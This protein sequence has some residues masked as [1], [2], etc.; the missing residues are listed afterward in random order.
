MGEDLAEKTEEKDATTAPQNDSDGQVG[1]DN[2]SDEQADTSGKKPEAEPAEPKLAGDRVDFFTT[3][4]SVSWRGNVN[5][6]YAGLHASVPAHDRAPGQKPG[7]STYGAE[8]EVRFPDEKKEVYAEMERIVG[9]P[10]TDRS[11]ALR[12]L[13]RRWHPDKNPEDMDRAT[14]VFNYLQELKEEFLG[15]GGGGFRAL[16]EEL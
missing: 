1:P 10:R 7:G 9:L 8:E 13:A 5:V 14:D 4:T 2:A 3:R 15:D 16:K 12:Q 11:R 6:K